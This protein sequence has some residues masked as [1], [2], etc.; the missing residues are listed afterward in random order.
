MARWALFLSRRAFFVARQAFFLTFQARRMTRQA[1]FIARRLRRTAR[2][3]FF[4]TR[5]FRRT[6]RR[7]FSCLA[8]AGGR[9][10]SLFTGRV[11]PGGS[12]AVSGETRKVHGETESFLRASRRTAGGSAAARRASPFGAP[13]P[14]PTNRPTNRLAPR[15]PASLAPR[16]P[17]EPSRTAS[18]TGGRWLR[19]YTMAARR[20]AWHLAPLRHLAPEA[21]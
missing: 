7:H 1:F 3:A 6:T 10:V 19:S 8:G 17:S 2:E 4:L 16:E 13:M 15:E 18:A 5:R 21:R 14:P 12:S 20:I 11:E 9:L